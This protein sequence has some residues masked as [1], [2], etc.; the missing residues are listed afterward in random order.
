MKNLDSLSSDIL[1]DQELESVKGGLCT[2]AGANTTI[3]FGD[4]NP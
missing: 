3:D 4:S 1:A 2:A